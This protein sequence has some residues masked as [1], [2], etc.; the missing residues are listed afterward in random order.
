[1]PQYTYDSGTPGGLTTARE[2]YADMIAVMSPMDTPLHTTLEAVEAENTTFSW[3]MDEITQPTA[4]SAKLEGATPSAEND[5]RHRHRNNV[6]IEHKAIDISDTQRRVNEAGITEEYAYQVMKKSLELLKQQEFNLTW[7]TYAAGSSGAARQTA[8]LIEWMRRS[9]HASE[10]LSN[11]QIAGLELPHK[12]GGTWKDTVGTIQLTD[13]ILR[14]DILQPAWRKGMQIP[15][16]IGFCGGV[17]KARL[18]DLGVVYGAGSNQVSAMFIEA[19]KKKKVLTIDVFE[20]DYGPLSI[21]LNR[22]ID[23][24]YQQS[25]TY[26]GGS[27]FGAAGQTAQANQIL[28]IIEP[29]FW[30]I[31]VLRALEHTPLGK[32]ADTTK[33]Y[34]VSE[35]GLKCLN[36]IAGTGGEGLTA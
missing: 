1:M 24:T 14:D 31:A 21:A 12:Y 18:S 32:A 3:Q 10:Y 4:V 16:S 34:V 11:E 7:S 6:M 29:Q 26:T 2:D 9:G 19:E 28:A 27:T 8:G 22:Y 36:P 25:I 35:E 33:G 30:Q 20:S 13:A 15:A 5:N 17:L 23:T